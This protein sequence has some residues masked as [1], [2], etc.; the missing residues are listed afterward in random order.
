MKKTSV[1]A[2]AALIGGTYVASAATLKETCLS[3][4]EYFVWVEKT[5][6]CA[7]VHP[8]EDPSDPHYAF[9]CNTAFKDIQVASVREAQELANLFVSKRMGVTC[10]F[11]AAQDA[12]LVGQDYVGCKTS[13]GGFIEFEFD[14]YSEHKSS[15]ADFSYELGKCIAYGGNPTVGDIRATQD[16]A[17]GV[18]VAVGANAGSVVPIAGTVVGGAA[19]GAVGTIVSHEAREQIECY[20]VSESQCKEMYSDRATYNPTSKLCTLH[21]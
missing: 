8:C 7:T 20:N 21:R 5:S 11:L 3:N 14:D 4:P 17:V 19:G 13:D 1:V 12:K 6:D 16:S 15:T 9:Y 2:L 10:S 18:G